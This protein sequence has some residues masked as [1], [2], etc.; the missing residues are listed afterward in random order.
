MNIYNFLRTYFDERWLRKPKD[1]KLWERCFREQ[2]LNACISYRA[3]ELSLGDNTEFARHQT[4]LASDVAFQEKAWNR[5]LAMVDRLDK[6]YQEPQFVYK[7]EKQG[8]RVP[9]FL[10]SLICACKIPPLKFGV[11]YKTTTDN[12]QPRYSR[13]VRVEQ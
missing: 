8:K 12:N 10:K 11:K 7:H 13:T 1:F 9:R 4:E 2:Y 6:E 5:F 3:R